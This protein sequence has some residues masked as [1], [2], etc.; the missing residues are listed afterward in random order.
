ME[1][2][3]SFLYITLNCK[4]ND[5]KN[6]SSFWL[7]GGDLCDVRSAESLLWADLSGSGLQ[8][9]L[10]PSLRHPTSCASPIVADAGDAW[11]QDIELGMNATWLEAV[12]KP[13]LFGH[14]GSKVGAGRCYLLWHQL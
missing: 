8:P 3:L 2:F 12:P 10:P 7:V 5:F 9:L 6:A 4:I 13:P 14:S 11:A 1:S